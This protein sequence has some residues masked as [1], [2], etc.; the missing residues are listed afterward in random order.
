MK[1]VFSARDPIEANLLIAILEGEGITASVQG[2]R[3]FELRGAVPVIGP[4]VWVSDEDEAAASEHV[5]RFVESRPQPSK[6]DWR[7]PSCGETIPGSFTEC[8]KCVNEA[9]PP[10]PFNRRVVNIIVI[11]FVAICVLLFLLMIEQEKL[12]RRN[13][14]QPQLSR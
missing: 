9:D 2:E 10:R 6:P 13:R 4:T 8:W 3:V 5:K 12:M 1:K 7:C 11:S 14:A